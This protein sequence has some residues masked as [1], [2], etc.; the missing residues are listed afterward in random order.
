VKYIFIGKQKVVLYPKFRENQ[1]EAAAS[2]L[3]SHILTP[4]IMLESN[5]GAISNLL[6]QRHISLTKIL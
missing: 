5:F 1:R 4:K 3:K 6:R 2:A